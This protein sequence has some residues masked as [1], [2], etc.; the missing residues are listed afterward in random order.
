MTT[1]VFF[2]F[3]IVYALGLT[4]LVLGFIIS[5]ELVGVMSGS[6]YARIWV[7][8]QFTYDELYYA[9][10]IFYPMLKLAYFFL[11]YIPSF[12][13]HEIRCTFDLEALFSDLFNYK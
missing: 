11:E 7:R 3:H 10:I 8:R 6:E 9:V 4:Y 2:F 13:T 5:F 1:F 12:F